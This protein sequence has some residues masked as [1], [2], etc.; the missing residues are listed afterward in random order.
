MSLLGKDQILTAEDL[1]YRDVEVPEWGG[2]VRVRTMSGGERDA[3][4]ASLYI[5]EGEEMIYKREHFRAKLLARCIVDDKGARLFSDK[6][7]E[8]LSGKS[9]KALNRLFDAAQEINA[10]SREEQDAIKKK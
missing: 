5:R 6:E 1:P 7:I 10:I 4:E 3:F 9:S 2:T 8:A